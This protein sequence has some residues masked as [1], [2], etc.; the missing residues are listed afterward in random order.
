MKTAQSTSGVQALTLG[1]IHPAPRFQPVDNNS[2]NGIFTGLLPGTSISNS[3]N[4]GSPTRVFAKYD[5]ASDPTV[6]MIKGQAGNMN[7]HSSW[8]DRH[9]AYVFL[10]GVVALAVGVTFLNKPKKTQKQPLQPA[11]NNSG[12]ARVNDPNGAVIF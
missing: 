8:W 6:G 3:G 2:S 5:P 10:G 4:S 7:E 12:Y 11:S 1:S 9:G